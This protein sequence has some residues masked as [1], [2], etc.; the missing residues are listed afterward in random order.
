MT[1]SLLT[2]SGFVIVCIG[3]ILA[4]ITATTYTQLVIAVLLYP[5]LI[6]FAYRI[7]SGKAK[8]LFSS[9]HRSVAHPVV[10]QEKKAEAVSDIDKRSFLKLIGATGA[11]FFLISIFGRRVEN[12]LLNNQNIGKNQVFIENPANKANTSTASPTDGYNISEVE[13]GTVSYYGFINKDGNW[14]IMKG[15]NDTGSFRYVKG[16]SD[17]PGNW[18]KRE[19]L[20][21]DY[22]HEVFF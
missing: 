19:N 20:K 7:F 10:R 14:F 4:F 8:G 3:V 9:A 22:F 21:Y 18:K 2:Y 12:L 1:K 15:D 5:L 11:S 16:K 13:D 17:F 6:F